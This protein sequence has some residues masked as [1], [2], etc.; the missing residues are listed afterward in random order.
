MSCVRKEISGFILLLLLEEASLLCL[1]KT[2]SDGHCLPFPHFY[3]M[4]QIPLEVFFFFFKNY[5]TFKDLV[6]N[7]H[8]FKSVFA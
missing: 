7:L 2:P 5:I 4:L 3:F 6:I 1:Y 8:I